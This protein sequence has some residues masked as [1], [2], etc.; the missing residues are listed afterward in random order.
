MPLQRYRPSATSYPEVL[1]AIEY[2]STDK[3]YKVDTA[4]SI[5]VK[6]QR[7]KIGKAFVGLPIALRPTD[8]DGRFTVWF[9]RFQIGE[10]DLRVS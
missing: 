10:I 5:N 4:A 6:R 1:P 9:S 3:V 7:I 2:L 8:Q